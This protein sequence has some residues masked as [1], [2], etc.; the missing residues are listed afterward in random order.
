MLEGNL[1]RRFDYRKLIIFSQIFV[2]RNGTINEIFFF[3]KYFSHALWNSLRAIAELK[4]TNY[5]GV[6]T[7]KIEK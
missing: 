1:V 6:I 5:V 4:K 2:I 7:Y 3:I